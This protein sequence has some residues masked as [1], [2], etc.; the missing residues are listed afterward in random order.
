[1]RTDGPLFCISSNKSH[2]GS[3]IRAIVALILRRTSPS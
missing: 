1:L 3:C 2:P